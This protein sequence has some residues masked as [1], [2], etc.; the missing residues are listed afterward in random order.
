MSCAHEKSSEIQDIHRKCVSPAFFDGTFLT[1]KD[2]V[3]DSRRNA[4]RVA[5]LAANPSVHAGG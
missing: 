2:G 4:S 5:F 3:C 1:A